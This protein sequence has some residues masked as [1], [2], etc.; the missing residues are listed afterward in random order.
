MTETRRLYEVSEPAGIHETFCVK[1]AFVR[2]RMLLQKAFELTPVALQ[3]LIVFKVDFMFR[4]RDAN[5]SCMISKQA[6]K[7][8]LSAGLYHSILSGLKEQYT[9]S[10]DT[11]MPRINGKACDVQELKGGVD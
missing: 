3:Y 8:V 9:G 10:D 4:F 1:E 11:G 2:S 5:Q 7:F 6:H